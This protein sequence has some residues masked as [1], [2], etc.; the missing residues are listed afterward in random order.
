MSTNYRKVGNALNSCTECQGMEFALVFWNRGL[1]GWSVRSASGC[2][3]RL[4]RSYGAVVMDVRCAIRVSVLAVPP[5]SPA[6]RG[7]WLA[8]SQADVFR[9]HLASR[10]PYKEPTQRLVAVTLSCLWPV[11]WVVQQVFLCLSCTNQIIEAWL[12]STFTLT[13]SQSRNWCS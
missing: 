6:S 1:T 7:K 13:Q 3:V 4:G 11:F 10:K 5:A 12:F 9:W 8:L 2:G